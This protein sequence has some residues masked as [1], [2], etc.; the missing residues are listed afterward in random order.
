MS[1]YLISE[2]FNELKTAVQTNKHTANDIWVEYRAHLSLA[3][4]ESEDPVAVELVQSDRLVEAALINANSSSVT[5]RRKNAAG[6]KLISIT[7]SQ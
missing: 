1:I 2:S 5:W 3:G 7:T 4:T 6:Q